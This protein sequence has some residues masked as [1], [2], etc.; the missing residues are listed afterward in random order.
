M[1]IEQRMSLRVK[2]RVALFLRHSDRLKGSGL[3]TI[4]T[5]T[6]FV[7]ACMSALWISAVYITWAFFFFLLTLIYIFKPFTVDVVSFN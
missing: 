6:E 1:I 7:R 4:V 5:M 3:V 2:G